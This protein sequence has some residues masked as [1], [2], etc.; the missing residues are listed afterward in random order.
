MKK[1]SIGTSKEDLMRKEIENLKI[2][3]WLNPKITYIRLSD[4]GDCSIVSFRG[5]NQDGND[6]YFFQN[7]ANKDFQN[8]KA[9]A[10]YRPLS[11]VKKLNSCWKSSTNLSNFT[12]RISC[13]ATSSQATSWSGIK[14]WAI[15]KWS[16]LGWR[17]P[18]ARRFLAELITFFPPKS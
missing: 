7:L 18:K 16:I 12:K 10:S 2:A 9:L 8:Q 5:C 14:T 6:L 4:Y 15:S 11:S 17:D 1:L 13:T 3:C